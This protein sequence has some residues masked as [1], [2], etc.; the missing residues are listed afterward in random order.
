MQKTDASPGRPGSGIA[1]L[2]RPHVADFM[3]VIHV[4]DFSVWV[5]CGKQLWGLDDDVMLGAVYVPPQST[6]FSSSC[7][8]EHLMTLFEEVLCASQA[9]NHV[10]LLG[11]FNAKIGT[12]DEVADAHSPVLG[13]FPCL[14]RQ[15]RSEFS[16][17]N[18][19]GTLLVD[20]ASA[21]G[22]IICTGRASGD[23]G[24]ASYFHSRHGVYYPCSRPDHLLLSSSH[25][26]AVR[27]CYV[28]PIV[29]LMDHASL[30]VVFN[31]T[32]E[33]APKV[34][35]HPHK[36]V[37]RPGGCG[38]RLLLRWVPFTAGAYVA[39]LLENHEM[40]AQFS[41]ALEEQDVDKTCF[42]LRSLIV[43]AASEPDVG[44]A[45]RQALCS[46]QKNH[47]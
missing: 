21:A 12:L 7:V 35:W 29:P 14:Q 8:S 28:E 18:T 39:K 10:L 2:A 43:Q 25:F 33:C 31:V 34:D 17:V 37:C 45:C 13:S 6:H 15:R 27:E 16:V 26:G 4:T 23:D 22:L 42:C 9:S 44:M 3:S 46:R 40:D 19:A 11:D 38:E 1:V 5:R 41:A 32:H 36:H 24:Q 30:S 20:L 47:T